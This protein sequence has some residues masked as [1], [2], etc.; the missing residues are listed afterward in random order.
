MILDTLQTLQT[1]KGQQVEEL[2][3]R[4]HVKNPIWGYIWYIAGLPIIL[5][6]STF[7][8]WETI[9][10]Q[11]Q[12]L[13]M[14]VLVTAL[15]IGVW[16]NRYQSDYHR[17]Y[18]AIGLS[19]FYTTIGFLAIFSILA[20]FRF[21]YSR[22]FLL[23]AYGLMV[24]WTIVG[25]IFFRK[26]HQEYIVVR[27]GLADRLMGLTRLG[28]DYVKDFKVNGNLSDCD[29]IV[30]D[31]H[32]HEDKNMLRKL[33]DSSLHGVPVLHAA[34]VLEK[35]SGRTNLDYMAQEGL[36]NLA[37][38]LT[39]RIFKRIWEVGLII[40]C[41]PLILPVMLFT[42]IAIKLD[43]RGP[44]LFTQRRVGKNGKLFTLYKFRSMRVDA[45]QNGSQFADKR[46]DRI[47]RV[48]KFIRK[49][50]ID[51]FPQ[52]WNVIMG[53]MS[54]IGPRPEQEE[55]VKY[56]DREIPFYSYRHKVRPGIT[57]WAQVQDGYAASFSATQKKLEYDLYY[58]KNISLSLDLLIVYA[59]VKT[60]LTVF[61]SR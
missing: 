13:P 25:M 61:G 49:F 14:A 4:A 21:Y 27:G 23:S 39:Y 24:I 31:L 51:E 41:A 11:F 19:V 58:I 17:S 9:G 35:Y 5:T 36:Y 16:V 43:S 34:S 3:S 46:D 38:N 15:Y 20:L 55:F 33:A 30:V 52:F 45:E 7:I 18:R 56:F 57:G 26:K 48:G 8:T 37:N 10:L 29:G 2:V 50:R 40:L 28:W 54:L 47:T 6:L 44:V 42:A 22:S 60:I 53:D 59:T 32:A 12:A 1:E